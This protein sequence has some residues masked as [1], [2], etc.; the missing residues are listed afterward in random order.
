MRITEQKTTRPAGFQRP[1]ASSDARPLAARTFRRSRLWTRR[2]GSMPG[3]P[4]R[5]SL[6]GI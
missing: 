6:S 5:V 4:V 2:L 3:S 1:M